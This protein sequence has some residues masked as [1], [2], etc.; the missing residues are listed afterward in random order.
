AKRATSS[1]CSIDN[2]PDRLKESRALALGR[3]GKPADASD[4]EGNYVVGNRRGVRPALDRPDD[5]ARPQGTPPWA[6]VAVF[7]S[8]FFPDLGDFGCFHGARQSRGV[9]GAFTPRRDLTARSGGPA[10]SARERGGRR[11]AALRSGAAAGFR[12]RRPRPHSAR[13]GPDR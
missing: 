12:F 9:L 1:P 4:Q 2:R 10:L 3:G 13:R 5:L 6:W 7:L 8:N 11:T